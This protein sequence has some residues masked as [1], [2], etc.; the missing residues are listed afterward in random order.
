MNVRISATLAAFVTLVGACGGGSDGGG[1]DNG[2]GGG[3]SGS[4][5]SVDICDTITDDDLASIGPLESAE[6]EVVSDNETVS[7]ISCHYDI[8]EPLTT[9]VLQIT[10]LNSEVARD[11]DRGATE[12][13]IDEGRYEPV[14]TFPVEAVRVVPTGT[15]RLFLNDSVYADVAVFAA[16]DEDRLASDVAEAVLPRLQEHLE[17]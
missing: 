5:L 14:D 4:G 15:I 3:E 13:A 10:R 12:T 7:T 17:T 6:S 1:S 8:A 11:L 2:D 9:I 16:E